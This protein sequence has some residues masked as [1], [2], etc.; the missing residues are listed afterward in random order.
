MAGVCGK[1]VEAEAAVCQGCSHRGFE[2][3]IEK[4]SQLHVRATCADTQGH[5][6]QGAPALV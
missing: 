1:R 5:T 4:Q 3:G 2:C 6:P